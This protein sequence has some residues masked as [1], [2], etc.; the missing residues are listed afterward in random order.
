MNL[1]TY[2]MLCIKI[3]S[4]TIKLLKENVGENMCELGFDNEF[5]DIK[6]MKST[7]KLDFMKMLKLWL[8]KR[9]C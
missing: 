7:D 2:L 4:K 9:F 3:N 8:C 6:I 5:L 1:D